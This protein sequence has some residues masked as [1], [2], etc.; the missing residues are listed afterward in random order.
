[1]LLSPSMRARFQTTSY[2]FITDAD[3]QNS[4]TRRRVPEIPLYEVIMVFEFGS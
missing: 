4:D 3:N 1:M 2:E